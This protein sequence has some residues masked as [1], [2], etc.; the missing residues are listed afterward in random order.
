MGPGAPNGGGSCASRVP[1]AV[2]LPGG[3]AGRDEGC[4]AREG[5]EDGRPHGALPVAERALQHGTIAAARRATAAEGPFFNAFRPGTGSGRCAALAGADRSAIGGANR[6]RQSRTSGP[7][8]RVTGPHDRG[9]AHAA[10]RAQ[11]EAARNRDSLRGA[12]A[13]RRARAAG[14]ID[15]QPRH[16]PARLQ[17]AATYRRGGDQG[18]ARRPSRLHAGAGHPAAARGGGEGPEAPARRRG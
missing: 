6:R 1:G 15:H 5:A 12:G 8:Q 4:K 7:G 17:D 9:N 13:R 18:A 2:P 16:R 10:A 14:Q 3:R 11:S